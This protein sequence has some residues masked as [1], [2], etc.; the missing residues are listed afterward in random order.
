MHLAPLPTET[1]GVYGS[2]NSMS[3]IPNTLEDWAAA[4]VSNKKSFPINVS[5]TISKDLQ[6]T[7]LLCSSPVTM[8]KANTPI[9]S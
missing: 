2:S 4:Q 3:G 8:Y 9:C 7:L 1:D 6:Y 5:S